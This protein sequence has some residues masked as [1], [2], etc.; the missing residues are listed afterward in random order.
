M[1]VKSLI[2]RNALNQLFARS[3]EPCVVTLSD[4]EGNLLLTQ[5]VGADIVDVEL[6][7]I[8]RLS[9]SS[10]GDVYVQIDNGNPVLSPCQTTRPIA[11]VYRQHVANVLLQGFSVEDYDNGDSV[12]FFVHCDD[13]DEPTMP[14]QEGFIGNGGRYVIAVDMPKVVFGRLVS[15]NERSFSCRIEFTLYAIGE[16][17]EVASRNFASAIEKLQLQF[18]E[19]NPKGHYSDIYRWLSL[20]ET[21]MFETSDIESIV[22]SENSGVIAYAR[23]VCLTYNGV[24]FVYGN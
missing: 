2:K 18:D 22:Q 19:L 17:E 8:E 14:T 11:Q 6:G 9:L 13:Y 15:Q 21:V 4:E 16:D 12:S 7:Q 20:D 23:T 5:S 10:W 24:Q 1:S 3:Y